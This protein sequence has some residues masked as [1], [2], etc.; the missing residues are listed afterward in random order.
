M[1]GFNQGL[2]SVGTTATLICTVGSAPENDGGLVQ[3]NGSTPVFLGGSTVTASGATAGVQVAAGA[4]VTVPTTGA[5]RLS[6]YGILGSGTAN[7]S[8]LFPG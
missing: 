3:N 7:V 2:V 4:T 8:Y 5:E 1:A 6:L